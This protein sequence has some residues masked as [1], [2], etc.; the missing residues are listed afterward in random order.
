MLSVQV[1]AIVQ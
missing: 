1:H